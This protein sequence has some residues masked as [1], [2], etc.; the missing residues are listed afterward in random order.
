MAVF[1][2]AAFLGK[3]GISVGNSKS[4]AL[5]TNCY[6]ADTNVDGKYDSD[7]TLAGSGQRFTEA[8]LR[9]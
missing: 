5:V 7:D 8:I 4:G 3:A 6:Q 9:P 2:I 1:T